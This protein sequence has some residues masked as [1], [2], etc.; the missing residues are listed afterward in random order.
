MPLMTAGDAKR[1]NRD[2]K[3]FVVPGA[4]GAGLFS[5]CLPLLQQEENKKNPDS[6]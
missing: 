1:H 2:M 5:P 6:A 4:A 3:P